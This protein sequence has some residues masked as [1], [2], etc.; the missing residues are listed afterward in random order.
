[1]LG[2]SNTPTATL[3]INGGKL[4]NIDGTAKNFNAALIAN[5]NGDF[6][7]DDSLVASPGTVQF[8]GGTATIRNSDRTITV[9]NATLSFAGPV[10]QDGTDR[11]LTKAG[12]GTLSLNGSNTYNGSTTISAGQIN[13][14]SDGTLGTGVG[15]LVLAGGKLNSTASRGV[16]SDPIP[17]P[18][19]VTADSEVTTTSAAA[20]VD[21]NLSSSTVSGSGKITFRNDGGAGAGLFQPRFTGSGAG[22]NPGP[23]QIDN[24]ANGTTQLNSFNT[25][26]TTQTFAGT[27]SGT[28]SYN[29]SAS[30]AGSGGMTE[31]TGSNTYSGGT[32]VNRGTLLANNTSGSASGTGAVSIGS[33][34]TLGGKGSVDGLVT[35]NNFGI[36]AP[37]NPGVNNGIDTLTL[38][39]GLTVLEGGNLN[40]DLGAPGTNDKIDL[41]SSTLILP[42]TSLPSTAFVNLTDVGGLAV[43]TYTLIDYGTNDPGGSLSNVAVVG[44]GGFN[45]SLFDN[46]GATTIELHVTTPVVGLPGDFNSDGKVDAGDYVT[47]RKNN[48]TNNALANDGGLGTPIG[49]GHY[50]LWRANFGNPPGAGSGLGGAAVPEPSTIALVLIGLTALAFRRRA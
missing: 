4:A 2:G 24:G 21:M 26:G 1:M 45:Y 15:S 8:N 34:G 50:D 35:V 39:G 18:I 5:L 38:K 46:A 13:V 9:N 22:F 31:F 42:A 32:T 16:T 43:G 37:G 23:I 40:F 25:T 11:S 14:D 7:V 10:A 47:W 12:S 19:N 48:G 30:T 29:R 6:G 49:P 36:V 44:P 20:T 33:N 17:N 41:L 28:G 3:T 27:I